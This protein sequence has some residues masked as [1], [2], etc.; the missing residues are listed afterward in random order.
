MRRILEI[1]ASSFKMALQELWKNKLRAFLSLF[2]VTIGIFC[3][4]GVLATVNSLEYN[5]QSEIKSLGTNTIYIDKWEYSVGGG[6]DY[7]WWKYQKR[8]SPKYEELAPIKERTPTVAYAAFIISS[9]DNIEANGNVLSGSV[10]YGIT[11]E[12]PNVQPVEIQNGRMMTAAEFETGANTAIMG[13]DVAVQLFGTE[14][15]ALGKTISI[16]NRKVIVTGV[17][18]KQGAQMLGGWEF[19][20][21]VCITY[22]FART[23]FD[24]RYA[25]PLLIVKGRD[26]ISSKLLKDDLTGTMR[27]I[28][29]LSPTQEENFSLNDINDFSDAMSEAF[30]SINIG[31]W[32]IAALSLIVGM[33]G[34]ANIMFVTVRERTGQIGLKKAVGA[35]SSVI[36]TEFLLESAFLCII[37]GMIG[38]ILVFIMTKIV[39]IIFH[40]PIF[41]STSNMLLSIGICIIVGVLAG[42]IPASQ[43]ARMNP[44]V[45]IRSK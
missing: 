36:L 10:V 8:P 14:E 7:P 2:G 40:F 38:L 32:A 29:K 42:I 6:P 41:I 23:M 31:G 25:D 18:K 28:R 21:S 37:G 45:A 26:D 13:N 34:I 24:E 1:V 15:R 11:P 16:R 35:K 43:A 27:S 5:I 4:I 9:R 12:F 3:I 17:M 44:V 20:K 39:T 19:D 30:V 33:F 22:K